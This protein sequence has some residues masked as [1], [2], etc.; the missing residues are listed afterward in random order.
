MQ[1]RP[2]CSMGRGLHRP[3]AAWRAPTIAA[4]GCQPSS[5]FS[6]AGLFHPARLGRPLFFA[7]AHLS[8]LACTCL[9]AYARSA[10]VLQSLR[11][12]APQPAHDYSMT[13]FAAACAEA[14]PVL[15]CAPG[16]PLSHFR[17]PTVVSYAAIYLHAHACAAAALQFL[18]PHAPQPAHGAPAV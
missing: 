13:D 14:L 3:R 17:E 4:A 18:R 10:D 1:L 16:H 11:P 12:R 15:R 7:P 5:H 6:A 2:G 8:S 9:H